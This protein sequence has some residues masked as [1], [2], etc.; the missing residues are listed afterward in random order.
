MTGA[1]KAYDV[2]GL[3]KSEV[4]EE[5]AY[6]IG[7]AFVNYL[8]AKTVVVGR[9]MRLS[10]P[11]LAS[12]LIEGLSDAGAKVFELGLSSTDMLYFAS[13]HL[14]T[15]G[16]IMVTA[17][18]NPK[19]YNG[20]KF[21]RKNAEPIGLESGLSEIRNLINSNTLNKGD[22]KGE[23][24]QLDLLN[25]FV[26]FMHSFVDPKTIRPLN[27][28][29][30]CGNGMGGYIVPKL[31][32][33]SSIKVTPLYF[34]LDGS[35]PNHDSN[36]LLEENRIEMRE[37]VISQKADLGVGLDGDTDRAF[38]IDGKGVFC[39]GD[40]ILGILAKEV[41][42][43]KKGAKIVYD[44]RC[45]RY[46][47]ET[48]AKLGGESFV[49]KVGHAYAKL[50]MK[51]INAD[52]GG[53]VSGHY[54]YKYKD[55]YFDSGNLTLLFMLKVLSDTKMSLEEAMKETKNYFISGEINNKVENKDAKL[56]EIKNIFFGKAEILEIDGLSIIQKD[57]WANIRKS[58]TEPFLRLNCEAFSKEKM[59]EIRDYFLKL[60]NS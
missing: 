59:I 2:R 35:F 52:F 23:I 40:F 60:I 44:V 57:F 41:L 34:E 32:A 54:Y 43:K 39:S 3:Y 12:S 14:E 30:D 36:P 42:K 18:H 33:N 49:G 47:K 7:L 45:S 13:I 48:V 1:F 24:K 37:K 28:V 51:E 10:S 11:S 50:F 55:A 16:A 26:S 19:E 38:F 27:V 6:K 8:K 22:S 9:D 25:D 4:N 20:F 46:V 29:I 53:E 15:D 31:L 58:N 56:E 21:T 5:L 17:S